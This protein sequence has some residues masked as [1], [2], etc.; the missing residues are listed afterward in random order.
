MLKRIY[1]IIGDKDFYAFQQAARNEDLNMGQALA[2]LVHAYAVGEIAGA[3]KHKH[4][5]SQLQEEETKFSVT[6]LK[7]IERL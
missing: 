1:A 3:K 7:D 6:K 4:L 5:L 2:A